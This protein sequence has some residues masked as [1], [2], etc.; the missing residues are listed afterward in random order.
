MLRLKELRLSRGMT[1][2]QFGDALNLAE[3]TISLYEREKR[4]PDI[5]TIKKI[6]AYFGVS[7]DYLLG[8]DQNKTPSIMDEVPEDVRELSRIYS[9][10]NNRGRDQLMRQAHYLEKDPDFLASPRVSETA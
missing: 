1:M 5:E 4:E 6:A 3:S 7:V 9:L 2:K 8:L 10:L